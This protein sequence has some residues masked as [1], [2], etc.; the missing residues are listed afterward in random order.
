MFICKECHEK[1]KC[2][3]PHDFRSYGRCEKCGK[4]ASCLF[5]RADKEGK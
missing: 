4:Q 5:C 1:T 2:K 3:F